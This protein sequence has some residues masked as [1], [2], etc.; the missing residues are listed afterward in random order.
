MSFVYIKKNIGIALFQ[1]DESA[2]I[3]FI[4]IHTENTF[5][6][7]DDLCI[8]IVILGNQTLQLG[9]VIVA[10]T[11]TFGGRQSDSVYQAGVHQLIGKNQCLRIADG[12]KNPCIGM[13]TTVEYEC[14]FCSEHSCQLLFQCLI[15]GKVTCQQPGRRGSR[16]KSFG[17]HRL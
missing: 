17:S 9:G 2:K 15:I 5:G 16:Q 12:R 13:I 8:K 4:S 11:D 3:G 14:A 1:S 10:I 7:N 6:N